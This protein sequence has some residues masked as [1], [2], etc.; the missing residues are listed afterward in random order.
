MLKIYGVPISVH[1]RKAIVACHVKQLKF[2]NEPVIPFNP[3]ANWDELSPTGKIPAIT[4]G[5]FALTDSAAI[6]AYIERTHPQPPIFPRDAKDY[7]RALW[8]EQ[9][10]G[11]LFRDV[12]HGLFFQKIIR[13]N[14]L[15]EETDTDAIDKI[16]LE[17]MPKAFRYLEGQLNGEYLVGNQFSIADIALTSNLINY[18][19]L[20]FEIDKNRYPKLRVY[21]ERQVRQPAL[22]KALAAEKPFAE[23]MGL[24]RSFAV[25]LVAAA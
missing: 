24:D 17:A 9:Y 21:F 19:Y 23:G 10:A 25:D 8:L 20:G 12:I 14:I 11:T 13:P 22:A 5:D 6:C 16:L 2:E 1:T 15:K 3:P 18:Y 7:A 4:D